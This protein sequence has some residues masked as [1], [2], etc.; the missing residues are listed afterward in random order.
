[1][2]KNYFL[3]SNLVKRLSQALAGQEIVEVFTQKKNEVIFELSG[4]F[5]IIHF[6]RELPFIVFKKDV[7]RKQQS[8]VF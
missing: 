1:M 3:L 8:I 2:L 6:H 5:L 7:K 4:G